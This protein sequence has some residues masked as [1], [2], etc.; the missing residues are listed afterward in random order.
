MVARST[1]PNWQKEQ[2]FDQVL[3]TDAKEHKY[4]DESGAM[5]VMFVLDGKLITSATHLFHFRWRNPQ[6]NF[7]I[8]R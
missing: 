1:Q 7:N 8:S 6:F 3:W 5:N 4:I 2:G